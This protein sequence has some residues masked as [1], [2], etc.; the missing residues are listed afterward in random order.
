MRIFRKLPNPD[1]I[2]LNPTTAD[3]PTD[4]A[5]LYALAGSLAERATENNFERVCQYCERMPADFSVLTVS[6]AARKNPALSD[7]QA[8]TKWAMAHQD[9]LF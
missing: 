8:F 6:Y 2:L 7:T 9:V 3:V 5:T 4:P 1:A